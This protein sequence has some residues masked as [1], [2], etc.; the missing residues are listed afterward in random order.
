MFGDCAINVSPTSDELAEIAV[1][2]AKNAIKFGI[3]PRVALLSYAT[4]A[5]LLAGSL[6]SA[7][8]LH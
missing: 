7:G 8:Q 4:G 6:Q 5:A 3:D 1:A 2:S